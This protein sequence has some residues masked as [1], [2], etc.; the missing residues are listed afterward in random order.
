MFARQHAV[1]HPDQPA[2][3]MGGSGEAVTFAGYEARCNQVAHFL[4]SAGLQRGDH[5]AVF[6]ENSIPMLEIEGAAERTGLYYTLIN[7]YLA[8]DEVGYIVTNSR[9]RLLFSS[10]AK[11][12]VAERAAAQCPQLERR[13]MAGPGAPPAGWESFE[14]VTAGRP[15]RPVPDESLGAA[16]LYSSGTTGQ[17]KGVLRDLPTAAP[18]EPL[19]VMLFVRGMFGFTDGMTYLNPA[20]LYH[21]APQASVAASLRMGCTTIVMEHFD[22]EQWLALVERYRVTNCQMVPVMF[23]R[24]LRLPEEVR[25]RY[26]TSSLQCIV[27]AAAPCPIH[28][29][30]GMIDWLGPVITEYYGATEA[31]GFTWCDSAQWLAHP[32]TVGKPILGELL[33]LDDDGGRCP[34]GTDGTIW[35]RGATAFSYFGDPLK[36]AE[37]RSSDGTMSTVGDVGHVDGE[38]Y[39]YLTDRKSYMIISGGVNIYPQEAENL[40]SGHPAVLDV[41]VIGVPNE[42]LGEEVKAVVQLV[43]PSLAGPELAGELIGYCRARLSHFKCP[44]SVDFA[45]ELPRSATGKLYKRVLRDAYWAGHQ[46]SIV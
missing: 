6:M 46:T 27:H 36:T 20:P 3:V 22:A 1:D 2:I 28:V 35:F 16:M 42:D 25:V 12:D 5:I 13:L 14:A 18:S 30:Q 9:S 43:D 31:N 44:R 29:K 32:G 40:L 11:R 34:A 7:S 39:L 26:D 33:V 24:L 15:H 41:A 21:S 19:P 23:S 8:A 10:A 37:G 17:P 4:R 38:G 45:D